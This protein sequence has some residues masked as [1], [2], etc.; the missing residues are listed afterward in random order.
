[1]KYT[2]TFQKEMTPK[3]RRYLQDLADEYCVDI[4]MVLALADALGPNEDYDGLV[5]TLE[6]ME[7]LSY[8]GF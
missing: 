1:M 5:T 7:Y 6:D 4:D 3:R 8:I 2:D